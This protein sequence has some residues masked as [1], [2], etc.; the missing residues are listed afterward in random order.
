M[1]FTL[2]LEPRG[3]PC[4]SYR[5]GDMKQASVWI[6]P[7]LIREPAEGRCRITWRCSMGGAC[8]N[9]GCF[10]CVEPGLEEK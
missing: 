6:V 5:N 7:T 10:Y 2:H 1:G 9:K 4:Y 3:G 8:G